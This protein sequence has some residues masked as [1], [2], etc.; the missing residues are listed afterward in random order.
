MD[1]DEVLHGEGIFFDVEHA[2]ATEVHDAVPLYTAHHLTDA[3]ILRTGTVVHQV[4]Q[5]DV[6]IRTAVKG[7]DH[8]QTVQSI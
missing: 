2:G 1:G 5:L 3:V 4:A 8:R 7:I 6:I